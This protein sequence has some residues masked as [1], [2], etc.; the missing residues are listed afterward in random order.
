MDNE[1]Q[2]ILYLCWINKHSTM[3]NKRILL[4]VAL[5]ALGGILWA[6]TAFS[7]TVDRD[8]VAQNYN[9]QEFMIPMRDGVDSLN[10]AAAA[11]VALWAVQD[12]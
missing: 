10:V 7:Q 8:W 1:K 12:R 2:K 6:G 11:S 4:T 9:K 5:L 3:K